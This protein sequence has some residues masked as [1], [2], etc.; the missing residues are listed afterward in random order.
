MMETLRLLLYMCT[1][2]LT[3]SLI[4][5]EF[6][7]TI[8]FQLCKFVYAFMNC[9]KVLHTHTLLAPLAIKIRYNIVNS[10]LDMP[11]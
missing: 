1:V 10:L 7:E 4:L 2:L 3:H 9:I 6:Y 8:I 5:K 11:C